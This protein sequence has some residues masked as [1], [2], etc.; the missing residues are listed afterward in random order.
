MAYSPVLGNPKP[1]YFDS[2]GDPYVGMRLFF[3]QTASSTKQNTKTDSTGATNNTNPVVIGADGFPETN[4]MIYG[5]DSYVYKV[6]AAPPGSDDP[7]TS[8]LWTI[9]VIYPSNSLRADLAST[10]DIIKG[11]SLIG[12]FTS[13]TNW[14]GRTL[15]AWITD[16]PA[17]LTDFGCVGDGSDENTEILAAFNS[18]RAEIYV[19]EG[20]TFGFTDLSD[21]PST[22]K[23]IFGPGTLKLID[24]A[25]SGG[26]NVSVFGGAHDIEIQQV[27]IDLN[28]ANQAADPRIYHNDCDVKYHY[29]ELKNGYTVRFAR[30]TGEYYMNEAYNMDFYGIV[31]YGCTDWRIALNNLHDNGYAGI[32]FVGGGL[33]DVNDFYTYVNGTNDLTLSAVSGSAITITAA[34]A[35]FQSG[36]VGHFIYS[37]SDDCIIEITGY[38]NT[39]TVTGDVL[40]PSTD[41]TVT[42][43]YYT[44]PCRRILVTGNNCYS[45]DRWGINVD[46][47]NIDTTVSSNICSNN[48]SVSAGLGYG[49]TVQGRGGWGI[50]VAA[51]T[52]NFNYTHGINMY[53]HSAIPSGNYSANT[54]MYNGHDAGSGCGIYV[55]LSRKGTFSSNNCHNNKT[56]GIWL[57]H[58]IKNVITGNNCGS[59]YS[60]GTYTQAYGIVLGNTAYDGSGATAAAINNTVTG[61]QCNGN[62]TQDWLVADPTNNTFSG[63]NYEAP[64]LSTRTLTLHDDYTL[65]LEDAGKRI[66][67][68]G[69]SKDI[70][71]TLPAA[72]EDGLQYNFL[73]TNATYTINIDPDGTDNIRGGTAGQY[74]SLDTNGADV[75]LYNDVTTQWEARVHTGTTSFH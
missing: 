60:T 43:W 47:F 67:N 61:N 25:I 2:N 40:S 9:D 22:V 39:T 49:I 34:S 41:T 5:D 69:A 74:I 68:S 27:T 71:I 57:Y 50:N 31:L 18:G 64:E 62:A 16:R 17:S 56:A 73:R 13:I 21:I 42:T 26:G 24:G 63:N 33:S 20:Y 66:N 58:S 10:S 48:G 1:Q 3:Y 28:K 51:N 7:P 23:R 19:P 8:P 52:C 30:C 53:G 6:V 44:I 11:S 55:N 29:T 35:I 70:T 15:K 54:C 12:V 65:T 75:T 14:V 46:T 4:K 72:G 59:R 45:N 37:D 38:T 36:H 32:A